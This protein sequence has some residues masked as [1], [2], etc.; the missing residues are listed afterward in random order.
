MFQVLLI[1]RFFS[2]VH[3]GLDYGLSYKRMKLME[4]V[5]RRLESVAMQFCVNFGWRFSNR[6]A[7]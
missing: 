5:C 4:F 6:I 7:L 2:E 1:C 3:T